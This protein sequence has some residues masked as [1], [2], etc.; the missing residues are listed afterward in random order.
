[1][2]FPNPFRNKDQKVAEDLFRELQQNTERE[3]QP[4]GDFGLAIITAAT[5]S[6]NAT[7]KFIRIEDEKKRIE[8]E[9][10]LFYEHIYFFCHLGLRHGFAVLSNEQS[11]KVSQYL[12]MMIPSVAVDSYFQHWPGEIKQRMKDEFVQKLQQSETEFKEVVRQSSLPSKEKFLGLF[13]FH[14]S[15]VVQLC[16]REA[17]W[18]D[19]RTALVEDLIDEWKKAQFEDC[20]LKI[21]QAN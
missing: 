2:Q 15:H 6:R 14:A 16:E 9:V 11:A 3:Y 7:K 10:Y 18:E 8:R 20:V 13:V 4:I 5:N 21:K 19:L 12:E 1:M 17:E